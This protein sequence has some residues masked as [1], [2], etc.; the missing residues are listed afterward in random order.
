MG[1]TAGPFTKNTFNFAFKDGM[2]TELN[3]DRPSEFL[4]LSALPLEVLKAMISVPA[5]I[6]LRV[7]HDSQTTALVQGQTAGFNADLA[8]LA[9]QRAWD[10]AMPPDA[11]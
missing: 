10:D 8:R 7:D 2:P 5:S 9:A 4:S 1:S 6:K 3:I 11:D